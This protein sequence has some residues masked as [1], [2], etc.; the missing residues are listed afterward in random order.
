MNQIVGYLI[1]NYGEGLHNLAQLS[2]VYPTYEMGFVPTRW[3][4][5]CLHVWYN[6]HPGNAETLRLLGYVA[7]VYCNAYQVSKQSN[8]TAEHFLLFFEQTLLT[9]AKQA[10]QQGYY[11]EDDDDGEEEAAAGD[12]G[13]DE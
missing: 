5:K 2:P 13:D 9:S 12:E 3:A 10:P 6:Y 4:W 8:A 1:E 11:E 7:H